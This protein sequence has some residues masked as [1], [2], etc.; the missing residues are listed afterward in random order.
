MQTTTKWVKGLAF[1]GEYDKH[2]VKIDSAKHPETSTGMNPKRLLLC[3]LSACSGMDVV[4]ILDKMRVQY[5]KLEI[6]AE[7]EQTDEDPKVFKEIFLTYITDASQE[8]ADKV[9]RAVELSKD[10]YCG[11]SAML[12]KHC[13]IHFN[14]KHV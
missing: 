1:E 8:D 2:I 9:K 12:S 4:G 14:I 11:I 5:S 3:S 6:V 10:K 13:P 7:A